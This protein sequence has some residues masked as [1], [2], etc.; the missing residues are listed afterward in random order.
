M[1]TNYEKISRAIDNL[2]A[3]KVHWSQDDAGDPDR[4][5]L[6]YILGQSDRPHMNTQKDMVLVYPYV[7][8]PDGSAPADP[9]KNWRCFNVAEFTTV[10]EQ[11]FD[12]DTE[13]WT[14]PILTGR[15]RERQNCVQ[16]KD[17]WRRDHH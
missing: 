7:P 12:P 14:A 13:G 6:P 17:N 15:D 5:M 11:G 9:D 1:A 10:T 2:N 16:Y 8:V 3:I 4:V